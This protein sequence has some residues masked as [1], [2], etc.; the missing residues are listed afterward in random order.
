MDSAARNRTTVERYWETV[1]ARDWDGFADTLSADAV[2]EMRQTRERVRGRAAYRRFN[3]EYPGDWHLTITRLVADDKGATSWT[4]FR[5]GD[6]Q[7]DGISFFTFD[8]DGTIATVQ[9]FWPE[10][11]EPPAGRAHLTERW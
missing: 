2:Y 7:M 10:P 4:D 11:Y 5:V 8:G 1:E 6:E 3:E 9:D